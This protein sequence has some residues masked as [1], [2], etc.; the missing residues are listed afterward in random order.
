MMKAMM[1]KM[2]PRIM[3]A[4]TACAQEFSIRDLQSQL[5]FRPRH[6]FHMF[7]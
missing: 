1:R 7:A 2:R 6:C 3:R 4:A 5:S